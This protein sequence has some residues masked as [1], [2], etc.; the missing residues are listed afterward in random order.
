MTEFFLI[1][2]CFSLAVVVVEIPSGY[3]ADLY[4]RKMTLVIAGILSGIG[5]AYLYFAKEIWQF[6]I[7]ELIIGSSM[8]MATGTDFAIL[9]TKVPGSAF[10]THCIRRLLT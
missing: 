4:G 7:Y 3:F 5:F 9:F 6:Y 8:A 10:R 1:Q 2:S